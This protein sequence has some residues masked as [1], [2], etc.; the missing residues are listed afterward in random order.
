MKL[1]V[2]T[3]L[4]LMAA[5]VLSSGLAWAQANPCEPAPGTGTGCP[6]TGPISVIHFGFGSD[7]GID[8]TGTM[9]DMQCAT[10]GGGCATPMVPP[11]RFWAHD[12]F[13]TLNSGDAPRA[14]SGFEWM[15]NAALDSGVGTDDSIWHF[16][17]ANWAPAAGG[18]GPTGCT[19]NPVNVAELSF[20]DPSGDA[21]F[22]IIAVEDPALANFNYDEVRGA[23]T[24]PGGSTNLIPMTVVPVPSPDTSPVSASGGFGD[25]DVDLTGVSV[26]AF[27]EMGLAA[28]LVRGIE[29]VYQNLAA[30]PGPACSTAMGRG[31]WMQVLDPATG[32]P[33]GPIALPAG[34]VTVRIPEPADPMMERTWFASRVV[35]ADASTGC[36]AADPCTDPDGLGAPTS[37]VSGVSEGVPWTDTAVKFVDAE[38]LWLGSSVQLSFTTLLET[39][40]YGF[41]IKRADSPGSDYSLVGTLTARGAGTTYAFEDFTADP[42]HT[43]Y[44]MIHEVLVPGGSGAPSQHGPIEVRTAR[45]VNGSR[46]RGSR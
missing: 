44:Y 35:Y 34:T 19:M 13:A 9:F 2:R 21:F 31:A 33:L 1:C 28:T 18:G 38:A 40:T 20:C 5:L 14:A 10:A 3:T 29:L 46:T 25:I 7:G 45:E 42:G 23:T 15:V 32:M 22:M 30:T 6:A 36:G 8:M 4:G 16:F 27:T 24:G 41:Q 11:L 39:D 17:Q 43:Y 37:C 26:P 12:A